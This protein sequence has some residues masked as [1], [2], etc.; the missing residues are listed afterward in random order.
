MRLDAP[1]ARLIHTHQTR[2]REL[3]KVIAN[4]KPVAKHQRLACE[5][6]TIQIRARLAPVLYK[7]RPVLADELHMHPRDARVL[8]IEVH[9]RH[10]VSFR[11][12]RRLAAYQYRCPGQWHL[13]T[14]LSL[15]LRLRRFFEKAELRAPRPDFIQ[16]IQRQPLPLRQR[17]AIHLHR[18]IGQQLRYFPRRRRALPA[19]SNMTRLNPRLPQRQQILTR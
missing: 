17:P 12:P 5:S 8:T 18:A 10:A 1:A 4:A 14:G 15:T 13:V 11:C 7:P 3:E 2:A 9:P 16:M 19:Q 6:L